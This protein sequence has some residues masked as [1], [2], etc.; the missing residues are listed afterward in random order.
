MWERGTNGKTARDACCVCGGNRHGELIAESAALP[1]NLAE[2]DSTLL[3]V[4]HHREALKML[5]R[6]AGLDFDQDANQTESGKAPHPFTVNS[7]L[8]AE[9]NKNIEAED[10]TA[11]D[12]Q[13]K[14]DEAEEAEE[15]KKSEADPKEQAAFMNGSAASVKPT[16]EKQAKPVEKELGAAQ[17]RAYDLMEAKRDSSEA[18]R[19]SSEPKR[20]SSEPK[21]PPAVVHVAA[22]EETPRTVEKPETT[23]QDQ[24]QAPASACENL[25]K[26]LASGDAPVPSDEQL[27]AHGFGGPVDVWNRDCKARYGTLQSH[28]PKAQ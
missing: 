3:G 20:D 26:A 18:K 24:I 15:V 12:A 16:S 8:D 6:H 4:H 22:L 2:V 19:D 9:A 13:E 1:A 7:S 17:E 28:G 5:G 23:P 25:I 10:E 14:Q 11:A 27:R 21:H